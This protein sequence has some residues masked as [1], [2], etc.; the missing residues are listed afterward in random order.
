M[1]RSLDLASLMQQHQAT[2]WRFLRVLGAEAALA[3]DLTQET[4]LAVYQK[5]FE[6]RSDAETRGYLRMVARNLF[7][8]S[9]HKAGKEVNMEA[10]EQIE[11]RWDNLA[12][13]DGQNV[14]DALRE[15]LKTLEGKARDA[16]G[17]MYTDGKTRR[18]VAETL[19]M[20]DDGV[21]TL[22]RRTK[23]RLRKCMELRI[24]HE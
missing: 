10:I 23:A 20:T 1:E 19:D 22:L 7:L 3:D 13:D 18:D 16:L 4:F 14:S 12:R 2:V 24:N 8:K 9:R 17:L 6:Q 5:P 21:K 11:E 15:C